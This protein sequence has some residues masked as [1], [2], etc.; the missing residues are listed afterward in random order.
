VVG[1]ACLAVLI[2]YAWLFSVGQNTHGFAAYYTAA[3]V[4]AT[5]QMGSWVYEDDAFRAQVQRVTGAPVLEIYGPNPPTMALLALPVTWLEHAPARSIWLLLSTLSL[6]AGVLLLARDARSRQ[7]VGVAPAM[8]VALVSPGVFANLR[9]G[10]AYLLVFGLFAVAAHLS[11]RHDARRAGVALGLAMAIKSSGA[12][13][14]L[15]LAVRRSQAAVAAVIAA[16]V[17]ILVSL[18]WVGAATW[19]AYPGYVLDF[20][21]RPSTSS[22]AYQTTEGLVRRLCVSDP[23]WNP[24]PAGDCRG[25]ASWLPTVLTFGAMA[26]T[27][28]VVRGAH[29][30]HAIAA[31]VCLSLI[32]VPVAE[33]HHFALLSVALFLLLPVEPRSPHVWPL[34]LGSVL[35]VVPST[36]TIDRFTNGLWVLLA[37]PRLYAVWVVW[38][39]AVVAARSNGR[40]LAP[41]SSAT[42]ASSG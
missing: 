39:C 10:Q 26:V 1:A 18:P 12:P 9:T 2:S 34:L 6:G 42:A 8:V 16:G 38:A 28:I 19:A 3:R 20:I 37:Y 21:A 22:T 29:S 35:L 25:L 15:L 31:A 13:W 11:T 40:T 36:L 33:D 4:L 27:F 24:M 17:L 41:D 7:A 32:I 5:N 23:L 14:L 30:R